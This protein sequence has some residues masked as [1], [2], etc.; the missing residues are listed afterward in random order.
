MHLSSNISFLDFFSQYICCFIFCY[1]SVVSGREAYLFGSKE[2]SQLAR[3]NRSRRSLIFVFGWQDVTSFSSIR[4]YRASTQHYI[5]SKAVSEP[6]LSS[7][8]ANSC[9]QLFALSFKF[10]SPCHLNLDLNHGGHCFPQPTLSEKKLWERYSDWTDSDKETLLRIV[11]KLNISGLSCLYFRT[12]MLL[13]DMFSTHGVKLN[14]TKI[15]PGVSQQ[16]FGRLITN[17]YVT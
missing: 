9:S 12:G 13:I 3:L 2:G 8:P 1:L 16:I 5:M 14:G 7:K 4:L 10:R 17:S 6:Y 15:A 11:A